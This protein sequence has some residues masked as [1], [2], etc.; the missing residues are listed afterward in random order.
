MLLV[1][2][3]EILWQVEVAGGGENARD[4]EI[5]APQQSP[6]PSVESANV[7]SR[8]SSI[9]RNFRLSYERWR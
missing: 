2:K 3:S 1:N 8:V 9:C 7:G 5:E 4:V 6:N